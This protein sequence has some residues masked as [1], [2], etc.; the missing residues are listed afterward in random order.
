[1][2]KG[3]EDHLNKPVLRFK[4]NKNNRKSDYNYN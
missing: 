3:V 4:I 2:C 1:M